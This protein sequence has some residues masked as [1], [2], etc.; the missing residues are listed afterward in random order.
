MNQHSQIH[1][2]EQC[3]SSMVFLC[4]PQ[5][6]QHFPDTDSTLL[7]VKDIVEI[8]QVGMSALK[9]RFVTRVSFKSQHHS[10]VLRK[11]I[12]TG[13]LL[14]LSKT[15]CNRQHFQVN[16]LYVFEA[17]QSTSIKCFKFIS[18][19]FLQML[20]LYLCLFPISHIFW[21]KTVSYSAAPSLEPIRSVFSGKY[22]PMLCKMLEV[23]PASPAW[24]L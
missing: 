5:M 13:K 24:A 22:T 16:S 9:T 20:L 2:R 18:H 17:T 11:H 23:G 19:L 21:I 12:T 3:P 8:E 10:A 1:T 6:Q 4:L 7:W 14:T 15:V